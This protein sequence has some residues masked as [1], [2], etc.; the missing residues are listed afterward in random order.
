MKKILLSIVFFLIFTST[1]YAGDCLR[2]VTVA[3]SNQPQLNCSDD[4]ILSVNSSGSLTYIVE[5][6]INIVDISGVQIENDGTITNAAD[7]SNN[8]HSNLIDASTS[9]NTA[10]TNNGTIDLATDATEDY[11]IKLTGAEN[12]TITNN[13]GA[14][15]NSADAYAI[16]GNNIGDC[17]KNGSSGCHPSLSS[18]SGVG[19]KL[20]NYGTI[21]AQERTI[22]GGT[23]GTTNGSK[24]L[25]IFNYNGGIIKTTTGQAPIRSK[26]SEDIHIYNY[27]GATIDG[28]DR[29]ALYLDGSTNLNIYNEGIIKAAAQ[30]AIWCRECSDST[31]TNSGT[32]TSTNNTVVFDRNNA[33]YANGPANTIINSGTITATDSNAGLFIGQTNGTTVQNTGSITGVGRGIDIG[34]SDNSTIT[35]YGTITAT[36]SDGYGVWYSN[37]GSTRV[38]NILNNFGTISAPGGS[39]SDGV[40]IG[41]SAQPT[42]DLTINNSG[43]ISGSDNSILVFNNGATDINI[44]TK[45]EGSYEGEIDLNSTV[46]TMTLDCSISKDQKIEIHSKT[47]MVITNNLCGNDTYE[48]LD[49]NSDPDT[50]NSET[51]GFL[52]V[53]GEDLDINSN[54]KKYR[55]EIFLSKLNDIFNSVSEEKK[56]SGYYSVKKRNNIYTN[57]TAGIT[58]DFK[59]E[60]DNFTPFANYSSQHAKFNNGES[61]DSENLVVGVKKESEYEKFKFSVVS[62]VGLTKNKYLDLETETKQ[63]ILKEDFGQFAA[64]NYKASRELEINENQSINIEVDGKYGL[65]R[66]PTYL[67]SFTDGDL[68]IDD[69]V[70]QV[71][72]A[73]FNVEYSKSF[74]NGF[75]LKPYMGLS[76][77]KTLS[78]KIDIIADGERKDAVHFM[79]DDLAIKAGLNITKNT[80]NFGLNFNLE[81]NEQ[82]GLKDS[83]VNISLSKK[84]QNNISKKIEGQPID[85]ELEKLFDQLQLAKENERLAEITG[86][87]VEE[88]RIMKDIIIQLIKENNKL[89]TERELLIKN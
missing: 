41:R 74:E 53:Y 2:T 38:N 32:I 50:D 89:K 37:D 63:T 33:A 4:D 1:S 5:S 12:I 28:G 27:E 86:K 30:N 77:N 20:Y 71:L 73:G 6:A 24:N 81:L 83:Q 75:V 13:S 52:Y 56:S 31:F 18:S 55:T 3:L 26:S 40:A 22:F 16:G 21:S 49:I 25:R 19:L 78:E 68:S 64:V 7:G 66:L 44:V 87:A 11:A 84:I 29:Y 36:A 65:K 48:I 8:T 79:D 35:N 60:N 10:I 17:N 80:D 59:I 47:N 82:N 46:T 51:N 14:T 88:N 43:T 57:Q 72:S 62:I 54:N 58:G 70:D 67:T 61:L 34:H 42:N 15:I 85:P 9:L 76:I 69:A 45:G 23:G 39:N